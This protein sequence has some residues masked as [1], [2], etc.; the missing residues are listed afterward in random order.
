MKWRQERWKVLPKVTHS[1]YPNQY[2]F[3]NIIWWQMK[4]NSC[5]V[6]MKHLLYTKHLTR[7]YWRHKDLWD[8]PCLHML[9]KVLW[10]HVSISFLA[11]KI[12]TGAK[13]A[14]DNKAVAAWESWSHRWHFLPFPIRVW[15]YDAAARA[16]RTIFSPRSPVTP[17]V[18][19]YHY[20]DRAWQEGSSAP[21]PP[22]NS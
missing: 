10:G 18:I 5:G 9:M 22:L 1:W 14:G 8:S 4:Y 17:Q 2:C 3:P 21:G 15:A 11:Q 7:C 20:G 16:L 13:V 19:A 12:L 6:F